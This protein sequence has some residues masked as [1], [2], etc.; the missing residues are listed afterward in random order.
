MES[1][2]INYVANDRLWQKMIMKYNQPDLG[3][4]IWQILNSLVP[5]LI[6]WYLMVKSLQVSY[7]ITIL[8]AIL[9]SGFLIRQFIIFHDCG[10]GSF[11]KSK[12]ANNIVGVILGI[13]TFTPY[14]KWHNQHAGHHATAVNLDQRG[15]G[16]VW[17]MTVDEYLN[18]SKG[19]RLFYRAFRNPFFM[20]TVGPLFILGQNRFSKRTMGQKERWNVYFTN[21]TILLIAIGM[22]LLIGLREYL[23]IQVPVILISQVIGLWLFYIQHQFEDVSWNRNGTW[24]YKKAAIEGSS[25]LK[26]PVILQWFTG[27]IGF[28]HV[29]HLSPRIPNYNLARCQKENELFKEVKPITFLSTFKALKLSLWDEASRQLVRFRKVTVPN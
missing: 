10:H 13:L 21:F 12:K 7:A 23:L 5:Y 26:L 25:F 16:D 22:S 28:H 11:F 2:K 18:S 19:K 1:S 27:N 17:T 9:A 6:L 24:D 4:S 29:H 15:M 3:K 8:L 14:Y 20:F